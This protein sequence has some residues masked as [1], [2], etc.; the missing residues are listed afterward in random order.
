MGQSD[1][2]PSAV[3]ITSGIHKDFLKI[4][5]LCLHKGFEKIDFL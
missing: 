4:L 2:I 5:K 3:I 1:P